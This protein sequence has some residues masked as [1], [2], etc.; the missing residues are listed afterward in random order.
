MNDYISLSM[1]N[2]FIFCPYS[3]YLRSVYMGADE[4]LYKAS[5]QI[6]GTIAHQGVDSKTGST[7]KGDLMS[8]PV[9][10]DELGISGKIDIYKQ[11]RHLLVERKN[12]L[13]RIFRGQTYQLWGQYFCMREMG[14]EVERLAF[15]E[16]STNKMFEVERPGDSEKRELVEFVEKFKRYSPGVTDF[17]ANPNKCVHCIY[18]NLCDKTA[19]DNVYT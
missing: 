4:E 6:R 14:Y 7:R 11:D 10:S 19:T 5:P 9:Y 3:I 18:C 13:K 15:Y 17:K 1:L 8:L 2:D 16:M 12:N